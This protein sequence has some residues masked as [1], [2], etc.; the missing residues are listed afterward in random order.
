MAICHKKHW[1][2]NYRGSTQKIIKN[3][4]SIILL[5]I[6]YALVSCDSVRRIQKL[7]PEDFPIDIYQE[8]IDYCDGSLQ[9]NIDVDSLYGV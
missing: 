7:Y 6:V 4:E 2:E 8:C 5:S 1:N 3:E 9:E